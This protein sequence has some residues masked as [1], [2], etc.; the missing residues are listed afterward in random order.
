MVKGTQVFLILL[1]SLL[2]FSQYVYSQQESKKI[3]PKLRLNY[4]KEIGG[5]SKLTADVYYMDDGNKVFCEGA[6]VGFYTDDT[7]GNLYKKTIVNGEGKA[8]LHL[9]EAELSQFEQ[10]PGHYYFYAQIEAHEKYRSK[11]EDLNIIDGEIEVDFAVVDSQKLLRAQFLGSE[12]S[13][14]NMMPAK[15]VPVKVFVDRALAPLPI[16]GDFNFTDSEGRVEIPFPD[17]L[18]GNEEGNIAIIVKVDDVGDYGTIIYKDMAQ[19]GVPSEAV[20]PIAEASLIGDRGNAPTFIVLS[21]NLILLG[22][23]GFLAYLGYG[24]YRILKLGENSSG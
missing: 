5:A 13:T 11:D 18:P 19:W 14:G 1:I 8:I 24:L 12:D 21:I 22:V 6:T 17:N 16:G 15:S 20:N 4:T 3:K 10:L 9:E 7:A 23:W 2:C